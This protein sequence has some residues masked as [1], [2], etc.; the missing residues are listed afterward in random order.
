M[1]RHS[2]RNICAAGIASLS[3]SA[4]AAYDLQDYYPLAQGNAWTYYALQWSPG[5]RK[6]AEVEIQRIG[7]QETING[8]STWRQERTE[9]NETS[10]EYENVAWSEEGLFIYRRAEKDNGILSVETCATPLMLL[11]R[12]MDVGDSRQSSFSCGGDMQGTVTHTLQG[13]ENVSVEAGNFTDCLKMHLDIRGAG[14]TSDEAW[15]LCRDVGQVKSTTTEETEGQE[16]GHE[17]QELRW[18]TVNGTHYGSG[19]STVGDIRTAYASAHDLGDAMFE[20]HGIHIG[21]Q[22]ISARFIFHPD[23]SFFAYDPSFSQ[24]GRAYPGVSFSNAYVRLNGVNLTIF[25][26]DVAGTRYSTTWELQISPEIGF[27]FD[28]FARM[29]Q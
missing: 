12:Q 18:A 27:M 13:I 8:V 7:L 21:T 24:N 11:P 28:G 25:D 1:L 19:E 3:F 20:I 17:I 29:P 26:V 6:E 5:S 22:E 2:F 10:P 23:V 16:T 9:P 4:W 14:W 15:W